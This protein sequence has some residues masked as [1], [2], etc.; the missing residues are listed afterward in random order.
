M[1]PLCKRTTT[2]E[3][4]NAQVL[5]P[6][7]DFSPFTLTS[8]LTLRSLNPAKVAGGV[9]NTSFSSKNSEKLQTHC[10]NPITNVQ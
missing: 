7:L 5:S 1:T 3:N 10:K 2:V 8:E 9:Q 6:E 4:I